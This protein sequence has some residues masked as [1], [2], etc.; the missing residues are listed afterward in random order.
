MALQLCQRYADVRNY[1][2]LT[3]PRPCCC[4]PAVGCSSAGSELPAPHP[5]SRG[6][7]GSPLNSHTRINLVRSALLELQCPCPRPLAARSSRQLVSCLLRRAA[8]AAGAAGSAGSQ[9]R[10]SR[11]RS[12][13]IWSGPGCGCCTR[14]SWR[15]AEG[16][17]RGP[18]NTRGPQSRT[19]TGDYH[20]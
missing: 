10:A 20:W 16:A 8:G 6:G 13:T 7:E 1:P 14:G 18:A 4:S 11:A 12:D 9:V 5:T 2:P 15:R 3:R 19:T 17:E